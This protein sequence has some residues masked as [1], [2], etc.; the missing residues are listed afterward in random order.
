MKPFRIRPY[1]AIGGVILMYEGWQ[2]WWFPSIEAAMQGV[3]QLTGKANLC[4]AIP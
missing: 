3:A 4:A 2:S 1:R